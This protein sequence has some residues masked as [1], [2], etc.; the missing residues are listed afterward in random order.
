M[1]RMTPPPPAVV[2]M[3]GALRALRR[4]RGQ[5]DEL[6]LDVPATGVS[7]R[8]LAADLGL[9]I[10]R[11]EGVFC[12]HVIHALDCV[13]MPGDEV[14]FVPVGTPGPH[15]YFLGLYRAGRESE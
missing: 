2:R 6:A 7:A 3:F 9:P 5:A 14:A 8:E 15:R 4:E 12:N 1:P 11:I 10:E 13:V